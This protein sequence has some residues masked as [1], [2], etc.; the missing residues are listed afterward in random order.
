M[1][2]F[3]V[4]Q[5]ALGAG[6]TDADPSLWKELALDNLYQTILVQ[7]EDLAHSLAQQQH[8]STFFS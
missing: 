3:A 6:E 8:F 7:L 1:P 5:I 4:P 2:Q